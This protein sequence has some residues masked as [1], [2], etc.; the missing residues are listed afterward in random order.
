L[1]TEGGLFRAIRPHVAGFYRSLLDRGVVSRLVGAGLLVE[2]DVS[3]RPC[4]EPAPAFLVEHATVS[5]LSYCVEWPPSMLRDAALL[6]IDLADALVDER[7]TLQDAYPWNVLF[8]GASPV[9]VDFTSIVP[10]HPSLL[11]PAYAQFQACFLR[12]LYLAGMG[13]ADIARALL[14]DSVN[15]VGLAAFL[16]HSTVRAR[17]RHPGWTVAASVDRLLQRRG[18]LRERVRELSKRASIAIAPKVRHRFFDGLRR[19]IQGLG[20]RGSAGEWASYYDEIPNAVAGERKVAAVGALLDR[21]RPATVL[22]LGCNTGRF[23]LMAAER[24]ARVLAV[25]SS[26]ACCERLYAEARRR[27]LPITPLVVDAL[28]PTPSFGFM[29]RQFPPFLERAASDLV[30]CLGLMHH[31]HVSGRQP[32][33]AIAAMLGDLSRRDLVFEFVAA[34]DANVERI[35]SNRVIDYSLRDVRDALGRHFTRIEDVASDRETRRLLLCSR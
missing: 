16:R 20:L 32:L 11:W 31:L 30:L 27:R 25:D 14:H 7:C 13:K 21:L 28:L 9:H 18:G 1:H 34:D 2:T 35:E 6:T 29:A 24:G 19:E 5:P 12:P 3:E 33:D 22:D 15:G 26:D 17:L 8:R 10:E 23:S 4:P